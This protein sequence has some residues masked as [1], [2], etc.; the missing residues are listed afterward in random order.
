MLKFEFEDP[1][2]MI[3]NFVIKKFSSNDRMIKM[4]RISKNTQIILERTNE[5][6]LKAF[7]RFA[8]RS[9]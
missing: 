6:K 8:K 2:F 7:P 4:A 1:R 5:F 3:Q 9:F